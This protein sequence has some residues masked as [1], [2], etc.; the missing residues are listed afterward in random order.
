M[1]CYRLFLWQLARYPSSIHLAHF[2]R[3]NHQRLFCHPKLRKASAEVKDKLKT[4]SPS[5]VDRLLRPVQAE[6]LAKRR[7]KSNPFASWLKKRIPV[8]T[9][10]DKPK[11]QFGY[12]EVDL[13]S[14][15]GQSPCGEFAYTLVVTEI[16]TGWTELRLLRNKAH[17]WML[18]AMKSIFR[19]LSFQ[20][21]AIHSDNGSE[22]INRALAAFAEE[23]KLPFTRSR[24]YQKNDSPYVESKNWALVRSYA[25]YRRYDTKQEN[26]A[27]ARLDR[28]IALKHNLFMPSMKLVAKERVG[29]RVSKRYNVDTPLQRLLA[30]PELAKRYREKL[31]RLLAGTDLLRLLYDL[32]RAE[33]RL[34]A[35]HRGKYASGVPTQE[36]A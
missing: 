34:D 27:L 11:N 9:Y 5:T 14:H 13:V 2:I 23:Q 15:G 30:R 25:G 8:E 19:S 20:P 3:L 29:P 22:F 28:L 10:H 26:L 16:I 4:I 1:L 33:R 7:Y 32:R 12:L 21:T 36:V 18:L 17:I 24:A 31:E 35:G 6:L